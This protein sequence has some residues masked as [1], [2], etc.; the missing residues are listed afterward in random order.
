MYSKFLTSCFQTVYDCF[1]DKTH[2]RSSNSPED[3]Y[4]CIYSTI[5]SH[6]II[7]IGK[8]QVELIGEIISNRNYIKTDHPGQMHSTRTFIFLENLLKIPA[9]NSD[10][11][12]IFVLNLTFLCT[13]EDSD[14]FFRTL[15]EI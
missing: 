9:K 11:F 12:H 6:I 5:T 13:S 8:I 1:F 4:V 2:K 14:C 10:D 7:G 15:R 3:S